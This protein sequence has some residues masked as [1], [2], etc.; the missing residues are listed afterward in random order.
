MSCAG[1]AGPS[2]PASITCTL[3]TASY[4]GLQ[5]VQFTASAGGAGATTATVLVLKG[6]YVAMGDSYAAGLG[7]DSY[8][9]PD[10]GCHRST[11]YAWG[12]LLAQALGIA[13]ANPPQAAGTD[14]FRF[15]A[16]SGAKIPDLGADSNNGIFGSQIMQLNNNVALV[17]LSVGGND[18]GFPQI[19]A[20]CFKLFLQAYVGQSR[21]CRSQD[22]AVRQNID[23]LA[24]PLLQLYGAISHA[25]PRARVVVMGYP[26]V[27][28]N[29]PQDGPSS[30]KACGNPDAQD[31]VWLNQMADKLDSVL[32]QTIDREV[33][34]GGN[35]EYVDGSQAFQGHGACEDNPWIH[36][37]EL[38]PNN[39]PNPSPQCFH[40]KVAGQAALYSDALSKLLTV[41][42][43]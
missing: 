8:D 20:S 18:A 6:N 33:R 39:P 30:W 31:L 11:K 43:N 2:N 40:P 29:P 23:D 41:A 26:R 9:V 4:F 5:A 25:A 15:V 14:L 42:P 3:D 37:A 34:L 27:F 7:T 13:G 36:G 21:D 38:D 35:F 19:M 22:K 16:C 24:S 17:T 32:S 1:H 28:S 10:T 12:G